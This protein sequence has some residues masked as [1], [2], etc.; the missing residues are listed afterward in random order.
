MSEETVRGI[1][2]INGIKNTNQIK[3]KH[4][5][6]MKLK[7]NEFVP[8]ELINRTEIVKDVYAE[9][10]MCHITDVYLMSSKI[11]PIMYVSVIYEQ[12]LR[13][14]LLFRV[15]FQF[16]I[17][18]EIK[19]VKD[20]LENHIEGTFSIEL[21][22]DNKKQKLEDN[23]KSYIGNDK[24]YNKLNEFVTNNDMKSL[25]ADLVDEINLRLKEQYQEYFDA[26]SIP[27]NII[28]L[29]NMKFN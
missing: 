18:S 4:L 12:P 3:I 28:S 8:D 27:K 7:K 6:N 29:K 15:Y 1:F 5:E 11:L 9:I 20:L 24:M 19:S 22:L 13:R 25:I 16:E 14:F 23:I 17:L 26:Y 10:Y 2:S 21:D